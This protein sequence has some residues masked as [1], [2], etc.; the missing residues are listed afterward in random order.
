MKN[1]RLIRE[2]E[3]AVSP[4]IATILMVAITVVLAAVLYVMVS[5]LLTGPGATRPVVTF[6]ATTS[7]TNGFQFSVAAASQ[8]VGPANYKVNLQVNSTTG[9]SVALATSMTMTVPAPVTATYTI[10]WLDP[11][12][13][14]TLNGGDTFQVTRTG[15]VQVQTTYTFYLLW[16]D[17]TTIQQHVYN[18]A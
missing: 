12:G 14:R 18:L 13:E 17:G 9:T 6:G 2:D 3:S 1:L 5:G 8:N 10:A 4:V 16:S 7:I 11:G 15:G